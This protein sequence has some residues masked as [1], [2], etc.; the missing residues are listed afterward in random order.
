MRSNILS[1]I[2]SIL[3]VKRP[4]GSLRIY[5]NY[6]V[7]NFLTIKNR[8]T[9]SLA[10]DILIRLYTA[11]LFSKFDIITAFNKIRIEKEDK[12]KIAFLT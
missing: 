7:L 10:R 2:V 11:K 9:S 3:I 6:R 12:D 4:N 5:I 8:N 1:Y